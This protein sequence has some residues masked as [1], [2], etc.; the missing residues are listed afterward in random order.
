M[1]ANDYKKVYG[2]ETPGR[3]HLT[4]PDSDFF[5]AVPLWVEKFLLKDTR[6]KKFR[7]RK[8]VLKREIMKAIYRGMDSAVK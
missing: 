1:K 3:F 4:S 6:S 5:W 8:K 2:E 7:V